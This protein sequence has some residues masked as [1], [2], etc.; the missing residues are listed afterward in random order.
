[1]A[2]TV[3]FMGCTMNNRITVQCIPPICHVEFSSSNGMDTVTGMP[4]RDIICT[5]SGRYTAAMVTDITSIRCN[6]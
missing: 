5:P 6:P 1:M 3:A 2:C 4:M